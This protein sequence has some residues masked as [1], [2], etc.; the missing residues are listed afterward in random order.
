MANTTKLRK[1]S[2]F[3]RK[4]NMST[5]ILYSKMLSAMASFI[6]KTGAPEVTCLN[7]EVYAT[8]A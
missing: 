5:Q 7:G 4:H 6:R 2:G 1:Q 3:F 8:E